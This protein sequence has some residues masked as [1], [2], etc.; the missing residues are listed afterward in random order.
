[1][2]EPPIA[3]TLAVAVALAVSGGAQLV[4]EDHCV[5]RGIASQYSPGVMQAVVR[6]RQLMKQL[7]D[8][9]PPVDGYIAA[10]D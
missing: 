3:V 6:N 4:A 7:P 1:M 9:L 10:K 5:E 2:I 8:P